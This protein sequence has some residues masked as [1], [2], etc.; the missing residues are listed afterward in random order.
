MIRSSRLNWTN[1]P[2]GKIVSREFSVPVL[3]ERDVRAA[4]YGERIFGKAKGVSSFVYV[5]IGKGGIGAGIVIDDNP[6]PGANMRAGELGHITV[7]LGGER[8]SCGNAGC[9]G[10]F[11]GG[12]VPDIQTDTLIEYCGAG[13]VNL[14]NLIDPEM[15]ILG[16]EYIDSIPG[17]ATAIGEFVHNRVLPVPIDSLKVVPSE[18][19]PKA[20]LLG[21][22]SLVFNSI[23]GA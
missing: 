2:L 10:T 22:A 23:L 18:L 4:A 20:Y 19:G 21:M 15:V 3:I 17:L 7:A 5:T 6:Y 8:C 9:L 11:I 14:V 13:I 1:V 16:G 12:D